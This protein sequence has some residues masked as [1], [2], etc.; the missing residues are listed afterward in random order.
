MT[1][2]PAP[3]ATRGK[4]DGRALIAVLLAVALAT[5]DTAIANT[6]V[7]MIARDLLASPANSIWVINAYQLGAVAALL[8]CAALGDR[9]GPRRIFLGGLAFFTVSSL[10]CALAGSLPALAGARALQGI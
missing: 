10:A 1:A 6:A 9:W 7:P 8:P 3:A 4:L 5:L 2:P